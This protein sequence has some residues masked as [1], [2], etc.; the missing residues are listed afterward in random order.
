VVSTLIFLA[1]VA[2]SQGVSVA[3]MDKEILDKV[4]EMDQAIEQQVA[5]AQLSWFQA[6]LVRLGLGDWIGLLSVDALKQYL[7][8]L[9]K[10]LETKVEEQKTLAR[11]QSEQLQG[12]LQEKAASWKDALPEVIKS[13]IAAN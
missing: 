11:Q 2:H 10:N 12:K 13:K 8:T 1:H 9:K 7:A 3:E 6:L 5:T 4:G